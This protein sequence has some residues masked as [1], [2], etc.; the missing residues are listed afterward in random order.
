MLASKPISRGSCISRSTRRTL[1]YIRSSRTMKSILAI[2]MSVGTSSTSDASNAKRNWVCFPRQPG[3]PIGPKQSK[4][5]TEL[6]DEF[7]DWE[8]RRMTALAGM[9]DRVDQEVGRLITDLKSNREF[10][11]T[12]ILFMSDN[13]ACPY[14]RTSVGRKKPPY[15]PSTSWSDS[16]GWAWARNTP[17]RFFKQNQFEGGVMSPAIAH[18]PAGLKRQPGSIVRSPVHLVDIYP[19][20]AEVCEA[21]IPMEWPKREPTPLA[22]TSLKPILD[23]GQLTERPPIHLLFSSDRGLR[24]G[25]WKL[26]SFKGQAWELYNLAEDRT[27]RINLAEKHPDIVERLSAQW[28]EMAENVLMATKGEQKPVQEGP[29]KH[30]NKEWTIYTTPS[31]S[32][33]RHQAARKKRRK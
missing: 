27:E 16:T 15:D 12:L 32:T 11:N 33:A 19:T 5:G 22:G 29:V 14:D 8:T 26:V 28:H 10:E 9:I 24:D 13:G 30:V 7:K 4:P 3:F 2:T 18:W 23:G 25:D 31:A 1:R 6:S 17:F 20:L 21:E